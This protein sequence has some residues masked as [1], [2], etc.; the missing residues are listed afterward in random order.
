MVLTF[1]TT[2]IIHSSGTITLG[3]SG[4]GGSTLNIGAGVVTDGGLTNFAGSAGKNTLNITDTQ[5]Y[6]GGTIGAVAFGAINV[7]DGKTFDNTNGASVTASVTAPATSS[8]VLGTSTAGATW[9]QGGGT[10]T[11]VIDSSTAG[12]GTLNIVNGGGATTTLGG[13][14]TIGANKSL[15]TVQIKDGAT[16][17]ASTAGASITATNITL[18]TAAG[19]GTGIL[20]V[21]TGV[22]TGAIDSTAAGAG[23]VSFTASNVLGVGTG[24]GAN[25]AGTGVGAVNIATGIVVNA[26][27]NNDTIKATTITTTGTGALT[28][29]NGAVTGNVSFAGGAVGVLNLTGTGTVSGTI[30]GTGSNGIVNVTLHADLA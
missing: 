16:L 10:L 29:G 5:V 9:T 25:T 6:G 1:T 12:T 24:I 2:G 7:T 21:G 27:T 18:G 3:S 8:I 15:A 4:T 28:V 14:S 17:D 20:K 11:G 26:A 13:S 23:T 19:A 22:V 30:D